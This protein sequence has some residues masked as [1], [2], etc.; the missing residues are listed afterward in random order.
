MVVDVGDSRHIQKYPSPPTKKNKIK[1]KKTR[2]DH[3]KCVFN[4]NSS[5][6]NRD[7]VSVCKQNYITADV[8]VPLFVYTIFSMILILFNSQ[9]LWTLSYFYCWSGYLSVPPTWQDLTQGLFYRGD[10]GEG[11]VAYEPRL[12][13]CWT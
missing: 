4:S 9:L 2:I 1:E 3:A 5:S 8:T 13:Q 6:Y 10:L 12:S 11:K 7:Y